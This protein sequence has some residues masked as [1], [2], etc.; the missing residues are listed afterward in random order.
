MQEMDVRNRDIRYTEVLMIVAVLEMLG[1]SLLEA[2]MK[3]LRLEGKHGF[4]HEHLDKLLEIYREKLFHSGYLPDS[5]KRLNAA[6]NG[7]ASQMR[8][9]TKQDIENLRRVG[10]LTDRDPI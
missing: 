2:L 10:D 4:K 5:E 1:E 9:R 6:M 3:G 7:K 8:E